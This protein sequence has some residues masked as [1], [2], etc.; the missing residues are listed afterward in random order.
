MDRESST[1]EISRDWASKDRWK[2]VMRPYAAEDV[3]RLRGSMHVEY[4]LARLGAER[5]WHLLN[6]EPYVQTMAAYTGIQAIHQVRAGL[7]A[8]N[9]SGASVANDGNDSNE[10]YPDEGLY[11]SSSVPTTVRRINNALRRADQIAYAEG[12]RDFY[13]LVPIKA[14][15]EAGFG[16]VVNTFELTKDLIEAGAAAVSFEDQLPAAKKCGHLGGKVLIPTSEHIRKLIAARF[17]ADVMGVPTV[18]I[19]R[20]DSKNAALITSDID[21]DDQPFLTGKRTA[22]GHWETRGGL[23]A[24]I[25]RGLAYAP[26][27][28]LLWFESSG[29]DLD[30]AR[31]FSEAIH[32]KFPGKFLYYNCSSSFHWKKS[33][34]D[35]AIAHFQPELAKLGYKF[36]NCSRMGLSSMYLSLFNAAKKYREEGMP[37]Y[38]A[39]QESQLQAADQGT[40]YADWKH[41]QFVGTG[42]FDDVAR[43]IVGAELSTAALIG[44]TEEEQF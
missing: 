44:S 29:P 30:E 28:D 19:A 11:P 37:A 3:V 22:E 14:D 31:E 10:M 24:A 5:L 12:K 25:T 9:V 18:L 16:G 27:A 32:A 20:T 21:P 4:T 33:L 6:T 23:S 17:A 8:I 35:D 39:V 15:G 36:Q 40:G 1:T 42:Y 26:Y 41:H 34:D 43:T 7:Q 2:Q 13:W 38:A